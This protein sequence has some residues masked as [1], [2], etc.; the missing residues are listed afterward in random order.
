[1][2]ELFLPH[3][4]IQQTIQFANESITGGGELGNR[5]WFLLMNFEIKYFCTGD[6]MPAIHDGFVACATRKS[7]GFETVTV[8]V[9]ESCLSDGRAVL[10]KWLTRGPATPIYGLRCLAM[11]APCKKGQGLGLGSF[12][13]NIFL[14]KH[15]KNQTQHKTSKNCFWCLESR[16]E[17][18]TA[19]ERKS[20]EVVG[21]KFGWWKN[22]AVVDK[23]PFGGGWGQAAWGWSLQHQSTHCA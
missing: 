2:K 8:L 12:P 5:T 19:Q 9:G 1:M 15:W 13:V 20:L 16:I 11:A 14:E 4:C 6:T 10:L 23:G 22:C 18:V 21:R 7:Y 3:E 17:F